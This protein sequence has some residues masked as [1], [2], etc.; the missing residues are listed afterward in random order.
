MRTPL[1]TIAIDTSYSYSYDYSSFYSAGCFRCNTGSCIPAYWE[2]DGYVDCLDGEDEADCGDVTC[3]S[4]QFTCGNGNC[5]PD[6]WICDGYS[7]CS[8]D[9][10]EEE[11]GTDEIQCS[12]LEFECRSGTPKCI[13]FFWECDGIAD[14][15]DDSD[16]LFCSDNTCPEDQIPCVGGTCIDFDLRCNHEDDCPEGGDEGSMC[17]YPDC[18]EEEFSCGNGKCI[19][20]DLMC[21]GSNDCQDGSDETEYLC[22]CTEFQ[23][24]CVSG[25]VS[26]VVLSQTCNGQADCSDNSDEQMCDMSDCSSCPDPNNCVTIPGTAK[27][28]CGCERGYVLSEDQTSCVDINE[29]EV[30][31]WV[32]SQFCKNTNGS[33]TCHCVHNFLL[34]HDNSTCKDRSGVD[35]VIFFTNRH[36]VRS[37][38]FD[39]NEYNI[40]ND[41]FEVVVGFDYDYQDKKL[42]TLDVVS[43][44]LERLN[45]NG[46]ERETII[47]EIPGGEGLA[48]DW[49]GRKL[50]YVA[51]DH[52]TLVV[53]ELDGTYQ[54]TIVSVG[55]FEPRGVA[56][57]PFKGILFFSDWGFDAYIGRIA[58]D[59]EEIENGRI[60]DS[61]IVWPNSL[62][63]DFTSHRLFWTDSHLNYLAYA[64]FDGSNMFILS[65]LPA[66]ST[67]HPF[68]IALFE[69]W[70]YWTE[71]NFPSIHRAKK[72]T[73]QDYEKVLELGVRPYEIQIFHP[74]QQTQATENPCGTNNGG[75]SHLC[76]IAYGGKAYTCACPDLFV[77]ESDNKTCNAIC[78][79]TYQHFK[80]ADNSKCIP[81]Y[82]KCDGQTDCADGSDEAGNLNCDVQCDPRTFQCDNQN[83]VLPNLICNEVDDCEDGSDEKGCAD[84][85]CHQ[86]E[87]RCSNGQCIHER[88]ACDGLDD[89][90]DG[91]DENSTTC[92]SRDCAA[93]YFQC[94]NGLCI[95]SWWFCDLDNDCGD[96]TDEPL[97]VCYTRTCEEGWFPC[98]N[99][100]RCIPSWA[101]CSGV[102]NCYDGSD[103]ENCEVLPCEEGYWRCANN[104][105]CIPDRWLCNFRAECPD[106]SDEGATCV[107]QYRDCTEF[108]Y[109]C[110]SGQCITRYRLCDQEADCEDADDEENC[111]NHT[112]QTGYFQCTT[113]GHCI[114]EELMCDGDA[115]CPD[116]SDEIGCPTRYPGGRH[117]FNSE[118]T[119]NNTICIPETATCDFVDDCGDG[120]DESLQTCHGRPCDSLNNFRCDS[121][122]CI[123]K[124]F[125]CDGN[126]DCE[127]GSD[128][129]TLNACDPS[130]PTVCG[131]DEFTCGD[132]E[133]IPF[134]DLCDGVSHCQDFTD[135]LCMTGTCGPE[136]CKQNCTEIGE[137]Y[138]CYC[139]TGYR[140]SQ[141]LHSCYDVNECEEASPCIQLCNNTQPGYEC[142]CNEGFFAVGPNT[143][144]PKEGEPVLVE[145]L[146][147]EIRFFNLVSRNHTATWNLPFSWAKALDYD[148]DS[149][150]LFWLDTESNV[151]TRSQLDNY[152]PTVTHF[153][154]AHQPDTIAVDFLT[155]N[156][157]WTDYGDPFGG[158]TL[159]D[160]PRISVMNFE[161]TYQLTVAR[162]EFGVP[163]GLAVNPKRGLMY[164]FNT[165]GSQG[166][167]VIE[168]AWM[169]GDQRQEIVTEG[170]FSV[171]SFAIDYNHNDVVYFTDLLLGLFSMNYDGKFVTS[172]S[173]NYD[174]FL[175]V[176]LDVFGSFIYWTSETDFFSVF[177]M[178]KLGRLP[179]EVLQ[180]ETFNPQDLKVLH[181]LRYNLGDLMNPCESHNCSHLCLPTPTM[182]GLRRRQNYTCACPDGSHLSP[183]DISNCI[184]GPGPACTGAENGGCSHICSTS[185]GEAICTCPPDLVLFNNRRVCVVPDTSCTGN[186]FTCGNGNC[187][188]DSWM[189]DLD[190][191]CGDNSDEEYPL[192]YDHVCEEDEFSCHNT[193][194]IPD[195]YECDFENDCRDGS[196]EHLNCPYPECPE[197]TFEC[198]NSQCI[199]V[200]GICDGFQ[201]CFDV[202][203]EINCTGITP[204]PCPVFFGFVYQRCPD[205][206][207]CI[208]SLYHCDG[209]N[210]CGDGSDED[211]EYCNALTC[212]PFDF[213]CGT[214]SCLPPGWHCDGIVDCTDGTDEPLSCEHTNATCLPNYFQCDNGLCI[215][216]NWICDLD[217]DCGDGSD[218]R[219]DLNCGSPTPCI[220]DYYECDTGK[221]GV[222]RCIPHEYVCDGV[223]DCETA[224]DEGE[225]C[226]KP[227][228]EQDE[229]QCE[230]LLCIPLIYVCDHDNDC[231]DG[232]DEGSHA[233]CIYPGC[234][235][236][237]FTCHNGRCIWTFF[238]CDGDDDCRDY[239]DESDEL[240]AP[241]ATTCAPDEFICLNEDCINSTFACDGVEDCFDG[242]DE[243]N[244]ER[245]ECAEIGSNQCEH[246]CV[247]T[248]T[249]FKCMCRDGFQL[250]DNGITCAD[251]DECQVTPWICD[252]VCE[253]L[254]GSHQCKCAEGYTRVETTAECKRDTTEVPYLYF[255]NRH[256]IR[257][258]AL[259]GSE[260][261]LVE[262]GFQLAVAFDVDIVEEKLYVLDVTA[263]V[264]YKMN[265]DGSNQEV[266]IND[267]VTDGEGLAIDWVG[268]KVYWVDRV[269]DVMEVAELDGSLRKTLLHEGL[270][271]PRGLVVDPREG[272][273]FWT[274]FG[275]DPYIGRK[276]MDGKGETIEIHGEKI[277]FPFGLS[278]DYVSNKLFWVDAHLDYIGYSDFDGENFHIIPSQEGETYFRP[279]A[280]TVFEEFIYW[281]EWSEMTVFRSHK[282][283]GENRTK[284][285]QLDRHRPY[286]VH[287]YH[288]LVQRLDI[289]N[290]CAG[291]NGGCSHLCLLSEGGGYSCACPDG[292]DLNFDGLLCSPNCG[293]Y[294]FTCED[295][296]KCIPSY[297]ECD[298]TV[299]CAD[300]SD[301]HEGCSVPYC[302]RGFFTCAGD[303]MCL[304]P[305]QLCNGVSEC[306]D[307]S[308][309]SQC[310]GTICHDW[311]FRC[312]GGT[313]IPSI[314]VCDAFRDCEDFSDEDSQYCTTAECNIGYFKCDNG[315]CI[316]DTWVCD[317]DND[318][319]DLSDEPHRQCQM[320][321]CR[322]DWF[323][324]ETNYR[325]IPPYGL[326]DGF[327]NCRDNSDEKDCSGMTCGP[328]LFKCDDHTCLPDWLV[329]DFRTHCD[330]GSDESEVTCGG[331]GYRECSESEFRCP[332]EL[333]IPNSWICDDI[334]DCESGDDEPSNCTDHTCEEDYYQCSSSGLCISNDLLCDGVP[335]CVDY[336]D[337]LNCAPRYP[338]DHFCL[339]TQFT[340]NNTLCI[341][342]SFTCDGYN[343]CKDN[344]DE[345]ESLC[346]N[347][348][349][350][351]LFKC[352]NGQCI[353]E[354]EKCDGYPDC[355]DESDETDSI[356]FATC[357]EGQFLC[358]TTNECIPVEFVCDRYNDCG[359]DENEF[360]PYGRVTCSNTSCI[361]ECNEVPSGSYSICSCRDGFR[362]NKV[363]HLSGLRS[364]EDINEC[365]ENDPCYQI[366]DNIKGSYRCRCTEGYQLLESSM[367]LAPDKRPRLLYASGS[368]IRF[369]NYDTNR[370]GTVVHGEGRVASL[371]THKDTVI[372]TDSSLKV[373]KRAKLP[374][375][376]DDVAVAETIVQEGI[377][378]PSGISVDFMGG[379]IFWV[380]QGVPFSV[381]R[382]RR[383]T[384]IDTMVTKEVSRISVA[385]L[386]GSSPRTLVQGLSGGETEI[387]VNPRRGYMYWTNKGENASIEWAFM[388]G[389]NREVL[390][391]DMLQEPAGLTIDF[392]KDDTIYFCDSHANRI[393][394][395]NWNGTGRRLIRQS[396]DLQNPIHCEVFESF[397]YITTRGP[398]SSLLKLD[399]RGYTQP[400]TEIQNVNAPTGLKM[401]HPIRYDTQGASNPCEGAPCTSLC[402][403]SPSN[404]VDGGLTYFCACEDGDYFLDTE[405]TICNKT[406]DVPTFP[407]TP[408]LTPY[409]CKCTLDGVCDVTTRK[410]RCFQGFTGEFCESV[411]APT[412]NCSGNGILDSDTMKCSC[413]DGFS[414]DDCE[415]KTTEPETTTNTPSNSMTPTVNCSGNGILDSDT[416]KCSCIDGFSGDDCE[417]KTTEPETTTNT[418]SNNMTP[419]V[420]CSGNGILDSDTMKCS[421]ID[422]FSG[423][424]CESKTTEPET[425]TNTPSNNMTPTVNCSGNGILDSDTMKCSCID[426]FSGDDCESKTLTETATNTPSNNMNGLI[427]IVVCVAVIIVVILVIVAVILVRRTRRNDTT[428]TVI[429]D[430]NNMIKLPTTL[431]PAPLQFSNPN[432]SNGDNSKDSDLPWE[433]DLPKKGKDVIAL[434]MTTG[435]VENPYSTTLS[436]FSPTED[437]AD[438]NTLVKKD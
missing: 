349:H 278:I 29:C 256:Y 282:F 114:N 79:N 155:N 193:R 23:F 374:F 69:D 271:Q 144:Y 261:T 393:E 381:S 370:E 362:P 205:N 67:S 208:P 44:K 327:D 74:S 431:Q 210:D 65:G 21:D 127:D 435:Q 131:D 240:C 146:G 50:Y 180:V 377:N 299:D 291:N 9:S 268:R 222:G 283:T 13:F 59:G 145:S 227:E 258:L 46:T 276:G 95:P 164:W 243:M 411:L 115:H 314:F 336:D 201:D 165:V 167:P 368:E 385:K 130:K 118:F 185:Q 390:V 262:D 412:V 207:L 122:H 366:C 37:L 361:E 338:G 249:S 438:T 214:G 53:A 238:Q 376:D 417:S 33:Y 11:C 425:T 301:E 365:L 430:D 94:G 99:S 228:C 91:S 87:F 350:T 141:E 389:E 54:K 139:F 429:Y 346:G 355:D 410:C 357:E 379:N 55:L 142:S 41:E 279:F 170:F 27:Y 313:C 61:R 333:C 111:G 373:I 4:S 220:G 426:G 298:G 181:P 191:D 414:G 242:S 427:V 83:C 137:Y 312:S 20:R 14:C 63:I 330:D 103:E 121:G 288:S 125:L 109:R 237:Q 232:S 76:L 24:E 148:P 45:I 422:G 326:C 186:T 369:L 175:P 202:S 62:S 219:D 97:D 260:Y 75:C 3:S 213:Q 162:M 402:L 320:Q 217:N 332:N 35:P 388:N 110:N 178:D 119:C 104:R 12:F 404:P 88:L 197:G 275:L 328:G 367:C 272:Y 406:A 318:C 382:T 309:E 339:R 317:L 221:R 102:D 384:V 264:I 337:E 252:Y 303:S 250:D 391:M 285:V 416:M 17:S 64:D 394:S 47:D 383:Q 380:D 108:E 163:K 106:D 216:Q 424:D 335:D 49:I 190:N 419:T 161:G 211:E 98:D 179:P 284:L 25:N 152:N 149:N 60:Q 316:P 409:D 343:H 2:C 235:E 112:C 133:C 295:H 120:S 225:D 80:C 281:T 176:R 200:S 375:S 168:Q 30:T 257:K 32:C 321:T 392:A 196:D 418:P 354:W 71:W 100:Y 372:W 307:N 245:D 10:D 229:Y 134:D 356:C 51:A 269:K 348:D 72:F 82:W 323:K 300:S 189:C 169:N 289:P 223:S 319:G 26:C 306:S 423:D 107:D 224:E 378:L 136:K 244:C 360:C 255:T 177:T 296:T 322:S 351:N 246:I 194:C 172:L 364:C 19:S 286:D 253:N 331:F 96:H 1:T 192:C 16:E 81:S 247:D 218:E 77:L 371:D 259:D 123:P 70:I 363:P 293:A 89:C 239:S 56:V 86:W 206:N 31:P 158:M 231:G 90:P 128:E 132:G 188:P 401:N 432:F 267:F 215:P 173:R 273:V 305:F 151:L 398:L 34:S 157:Y 400:E 150:T 436:S 236:N 294:Q 8:D 230:N 407:P 304:S 433:Y 241:Q 147:N 302:G 124:G 7:D 341:S 408:P 68:D 315:N 199:D 437:E 358:E 93:G 40:I 399:K 329:C 212:G 395:M 434:D 421:C 183:G 15:Q 226:P 58:T 5:I 405:R 297:F 129:D 345:D 290:P 138:A 73:G 52:D 308:D 140:P 126:M 42:Y 277:I 184:E 43:G 397:L 187:I 287:V 22:R 359:D 159:N 38:S 195:V 266:I 182:N 420:Y 28:Q 160:V 116:L 352:D 254:P 265:L 270:F 428:G 57:H 340:C 36:Y 396:E 263:E 324:C 386:D 342:I 113:S 101:V 92:G 174:I 325:C 209:E 135:E 85:I 415:S 143:C 353:P 387:V 84:T 344:S 274:D 39:H 154:H 105:T 6:F 413:I 251:I 334:E 347:C 198:A 311:E 248:V 166:R 233:A 310:N 171:D 48:V 203:D 204:E 403:V 292:F 153:I 280:V 18:T 234:N 66:E 117:C 78:D 156:I